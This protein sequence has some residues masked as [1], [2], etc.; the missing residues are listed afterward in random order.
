MMP[1]ETELGEYL[2]R[3]TLL[4]GLAGHGQVEDHRCYTLP[5]PTSLV[6]G[7]T[8]VGGNDIKGPD[9]SSKV[10][11][12]EGSGTCAHSA[13]ADC[14]RER[15]TTSIRRRKALGFFLGQKS[16]QHFSLAPGSRGTSKLPIS[17]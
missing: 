17:F 7:Q 8:K 14:R 3:K 13:L 10:M 1:F 6:G 5:R 11:K 16:E 4:I 9:H 15:N 2:G 12:L